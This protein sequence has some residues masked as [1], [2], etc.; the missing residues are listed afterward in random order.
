MI[1]SNYYLKLTSFSVAVSMPLTNTIKAK[2][3]AIAKFR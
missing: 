1:K 2:I 3:N